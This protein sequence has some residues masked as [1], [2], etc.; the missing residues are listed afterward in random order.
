MLIV[1]NICLC[2]RGLNSTGSNVCNGRFLRDC[3]ILQL[4]CC[5]AET[6]SLLAGEFM[7]SNFKS[8]GFWLD[9]ECRKMGE[10]EFLFNVNFCIFSQQQI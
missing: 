5:P 1:W 4:N 6:S 2:N 9:S 3:V 8:R 10:C 7:S